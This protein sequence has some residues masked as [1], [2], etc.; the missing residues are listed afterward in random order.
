VEQDETAIRE[1]VRKAQDGWNANDERAF[2]AAFAE[3][4]DYVLVNGRH[5]K[6]REAISVG[7][8]ADFSTIFKDSNNSYSVE[9]ARF[10]RPDVAIAHV[11]QLL[12]YRDGEAIQESSARSTWVLTKNDGKWSVAA[13]QN[14]LIAPSRE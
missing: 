10:I 7:A 9:D 11:Y 14:T 2:A 12:K 13:F 1:V 6:G 4:A 8:R 3:D 5:V